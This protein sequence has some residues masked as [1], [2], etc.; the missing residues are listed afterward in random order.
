MDEKIWKIK[1]NIK[2]TPFKIK[3][4]KVH[5]YWK[6]LESISEFERLNHD[7]LSCDFVTLRKSVNIS[8]VFNP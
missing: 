6:V 8:V 4:Q 2:Y 1:F 5:Q 7:F 3:Y